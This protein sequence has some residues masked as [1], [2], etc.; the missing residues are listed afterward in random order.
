MQ[1]K[2]ILDIYH[3]ELDLI[4]GKN[5]VDSFFNLLI[6]FHFN[7]KRIQL[8]VDPN[9]LL[10]NQQE[11]LMFEALSKLKLQKPIQ[12]IIGETEFYDLTFKVN[13]HTLIPR[14]ETEELVRWIVDDLKSNEEPIAILDIGTGS[15]CIAVSLAKAL[16]NSQVSAIDISKEALNVAR[17]NARINKVDV[18]FIEA[19]VLNSETFDFEEGIFDVI[20][21]NPPYVR[22]SEK[23]DMKDNVLNYEPH[24]ALFVE[25][26][27][28]LIF[29]KAISQLALRLL[30]PK[31]SIYFEINQYLREDMFNL[32]KSLGFEDIEI[33][34]DMFDNDRMLKAIKP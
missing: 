10:D 7:L 32:I 13:E 26:E 8:I 30:K 6:E 22:N 31:S 17:E 19:D 3:K 11:Q 34:K 2:D 16:S 33:R 29:Y 23:K 12:Q 18:N 4:Y 14:P 9:Y 1:L 28:A 25:N 5:E 21:S 27:D 20:V 15:G 24:Q